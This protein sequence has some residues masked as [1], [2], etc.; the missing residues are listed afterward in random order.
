MYKCHP[1]RKP[2]TQ[3]L[4]VTRR[5]SAGVS[6]VSGCFKSLVSF[7]GSG[8]DNRLGCAVAGATEAA[9]ESTVST[10]CTAAASGTTAA[11]NDGGLASFLQSKT[12]SLSAT[13]SSH[14]AATFDGHAGSLSSSNTDRTLA[15]EMGAGVCAVQVSASG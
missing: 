5:V 14:H 15:S 9:V 3:Q 6:S 1:E 4:L 13:V 10:N 12:R 2:Q 8:A 7:G 11:S